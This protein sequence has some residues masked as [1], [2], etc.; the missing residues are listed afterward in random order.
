LSRDNGLW[1]PFCRKHVVDRDEALR[2]ARRRKVAAFEEAIAEQER[3]E[4]EKETEKEK[5]EEDLLDEL[6]GGWVLI[7]KDEAPKLTGRAKEREEMRKAVTEAKRKGESEKK[8][9]KSIVPIDKITSK[10]WD[11]FTPEEEELEKRRGPYE[12]PLWKEAFVAWKIA[13][14]RK[15]LHVCI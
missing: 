1:L 11:E 10:W 3:R 14:D 2:F 4:K 7:E 13:R 5:H 8:R 9:P 6:G 15:M 12:K